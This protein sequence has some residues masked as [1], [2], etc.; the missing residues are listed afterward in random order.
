MLR[1]WYP[2]RGN[3]TIGKYFPPSQL[4]EATIAASEQAEK[5]KGQN[6]Y[7]EDSDTG[8]WL[9]FLWLWRDSECKSGRV[10]ISPVHVR[11]GSP[12]G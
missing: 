9:V 5:N 6:V 4:D 11:P 2:Q 7:L 3:L 12:P 1:I 10:D 8:K